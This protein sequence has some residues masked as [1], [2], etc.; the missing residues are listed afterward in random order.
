[1]AIAEAGKGS[2][3]DFVEAAKLQLQQLATENDFA[4]DY[5]ANTDQIN[6]A[7]LAK[8]RLFIQLN[9]PPYRWTPVAK[10]AFQRYIERGTGGWVGFHHAMLLG[11]FIRLLDLAADLAFA[12]D[13]AVE[14]RGDAEQVARSI[15]IVMCVQVRPNV[16][17]P[18][19][20]KLGKK[21]S[22]LLARQRAPV[23]L[24][25]D[26]FLRQHQDALTKA[27]NRRRKSAE[28]RLAN[29]WVSS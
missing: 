11:D 5:I 22:D 26:D 19:L 24:G 14:A 8:Y 3:N 27:R 10:L 1:M 23:A 25:A 17:R 21:G 13:K 16:F 15:D 29:S 20:V 2:H 28:P 6:D 18:H 9:Y 4:V 12:D 7:F